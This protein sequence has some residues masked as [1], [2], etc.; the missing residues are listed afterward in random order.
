MLHNDVLKFIIG[1]N[2]HFLAFYACSCAYFSYTNE[3]CLSFLHNMDLIFGASLIMYIVNI[4][5]EISLN[6]NCD[7]SK[8]NSIY[9]ILLWILVIKVTFYFYPDLLTFK[10]N[11][12]SAYFT[13]NS[14]QIPQ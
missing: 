12:W 9:I 8:L 14:L 3:K 2:L 10:A 11:D 6:L 5:C 7:L 1:L 4:I 13:V